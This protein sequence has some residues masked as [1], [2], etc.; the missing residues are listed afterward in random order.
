MRIAVTARISK[1]RIIEDALYY[2]HTVKA[3]PTLA[4]LSYSN[5]YVHVHVALLVK[6]LLLRQLSHQVNESY[7]V[8]HQLPQYG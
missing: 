7:E 6:K 8:Q 1:I 4:C 2:S 3:T 5:W